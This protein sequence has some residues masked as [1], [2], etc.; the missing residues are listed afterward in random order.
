MTS[1]IG[2][3]ANTHELTQ[4]HNRATI[5]GARPIFLGIYRRRWRPAADSR[6]FRLRVVKGGGMFPAKVALVGAGPGDPGLI[7]VRGLALLQAAE[8]VLTD[9]LAH[10]ALLEACPHAE[11]HHVG[12]PVGLSTA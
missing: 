8:V 12:K 9:A 6:R 4:H 11:V 7:T 3:Q 2:A 5:S 10:P 1:V